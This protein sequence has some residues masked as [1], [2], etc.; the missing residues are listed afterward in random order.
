MGTGG[1]KMSKYI[2]DDW[3]FYIIKEN[4]SF[5]TVGGEEIVSKKSLF[6]INKN[7]Y[8]DV[9]GQEYSANIV[10]HYKNIDDFIA[11]VVFEINKYNKLLKS[12]IK[13]NLTYD[14]LVHEDRIIK[15][16]DMLERIKEKE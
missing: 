5:Y 15:L 12:S 3:S 2:E 14:T 4:E 6:K 11:R 13:Q 1:R 10:N 9:I 7:L 8:K 16:K